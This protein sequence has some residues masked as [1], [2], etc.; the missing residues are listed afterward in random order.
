MSTISDETLG[1]FLDGELPE[2]ERARVAAA[3]GSDPALAARFAQLQRTDD[4]LKQ[5]WP[6]STTPL[7]AGIAAA[8]DRLAAAQQARTA[9]PAADVVSLD[10][11]RTGVAATNAGRPAAHV[12]RTSPWRWS[13]A[14]SILVA[15]GAGL[16]LF[17][18]RPAESRFALAPPGGAT[19]AS[20]HPLAITLSETPSG[21]VRRWPG[22]GMQGGSVYPVLSF[23]DR[24]G[25]LCREFEV[26]DR[27]T[28]QF[29]V[30][31]RRDDGWQIEVIAP[32]PGLSAAADGYVPAAGD[33]PAVVNAAIARLIRD[34]PLDAKAEAAAL[35]R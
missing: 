34:E 27:R 16:L 14:A 25:A 31:C 33:V 1:A 7:P 21:T 19:L 17:G 6:A 29:G 5:A 10:A 32:A 4:A 30:A 26:A 35:A 24:A 22:E 28:V 15:V 9:A 11:H 13:L 2:A 3:L 20:R 12:L 8:L 23:R 18:Q